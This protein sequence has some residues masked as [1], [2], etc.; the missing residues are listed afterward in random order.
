MPDWGASLTFLPVLLYNAL[1]FELMSGAGEEMRD[2]ERP[3]MVRSRLPA[4][5]RIESQMGSAS[6]RRKR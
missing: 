4:A 1:G 2:S 3:P 6:R 5:W